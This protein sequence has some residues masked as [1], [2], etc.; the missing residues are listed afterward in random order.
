MASAVYNAGAKGLLDGSIDFA[1]DTIKIMLL[2]T[3]VPYVVDKDHDHIDDLNASEL[4]VSGYANGFAGAG[5]KTLGTKTITKDN[6]TDR[7]VFD[8]A[9][10]SAWTLGA[11][12]T[13]AAAVVYW[14]SVDDATSIPLFFLDFVDVLTNGG[15]FA[16]AFHADG[17]AYVQQ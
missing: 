4:V 1:A 6:A 2:S 5:R 15:T 9:D 10:P 8:A 12:E 13:V 7:V 16:I 14:H 17:I 11:G 3:D